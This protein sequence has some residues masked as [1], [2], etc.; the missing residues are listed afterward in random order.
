MIRALF[1]AL[2]AGCAARAPVTPVEAASAVER[3]AGL[4][5]VVRAT[6]EAGAADLDV[7]VRRAALAALVRAEAA[8][9]GGAWAQRGRYDPSEYVR[10]AV[11]D[12]VAPRLAE[13]ES[14]ALLRAIV[15]DAASDP[16]TRG[17]AAL[18]LV[19]GAAD[20]RVP[21]AEQAGDRARLARAAETR[22]ARA[23]ALLLAAA[24]LGDAA[25]AQRLGELVRAGNLPMELWVVRA[26]GDRPDPALTRTLA[27]ALEATEPELRLALASALLALGEPSGE[28]A[29]AAAL[30]GDEEVALEA[31]DFLAE[32]RP[33]ERAL[34]VLRGAARAPPLVRDAAGALRF[35]HGEGET[36]AVIPLLAHEE[37]EV[38]VYATRAAARR[39]AGPTPLEGADRL[40]AALRDALPTADPAL[41]LALIGALGAAPGPQ[42]RAALAALLSDESTRMRV[43]AA[44]ALA[45]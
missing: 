44:A 20:G 17:A 36:R 22:G 41:Q 45:R 19:D 32:A 8:P 18:A 23:A 42:D 27:E 6:L 26:L 43:E 24:R 30:A 29:L 16:L 3:A 31:L 35:G 39:L 12:A 5:P 1:L 21:E 33:A 9:A 37:P 40:R 14:R 11:V 10:R 28:A 7:G 38:R 13:P 15:D 4:D 25:A 34:A 2:V